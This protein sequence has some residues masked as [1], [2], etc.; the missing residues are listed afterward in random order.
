MTG[1]ERGAARQI[2]HALAGASDATLARVVAMLDGLA[3]RGD[4]DRLLD[5]ARQ[6]LRRLRPP[7]P[8]AFTRLLFLPL[9]GAI[10]PAADWQRGSGQ[11]PRSA[12]G[13]IAAAMRAALGAEA[14]AID[15]ACAGHSFADL[16]TVDRV[17][18][19]LWEIAA[20][21]GAR[22]S[23]PA[24]WEAETGLRPEDFAPLAALAAG[25]WRHAGP[26]W[27]A[28]LAARGGPPDALVREALAGP[29]G[30]NEKIFSTALATLLLR[31][32]RPGS[33]AAVAAGMSPQATP[34]AERVLDLWIESC[35]PEL[36]QD[37]PGNAAE[38]AE[39]FG[40]AIEDL[41]AS[42]M[43]RHPARRRAL[44]AL[45][46]GTDEACRAVFARA[47]EERLLIPVLKADGEDAAA[48][49]ALEAEARLLKRLEVAARRVGSPDVYDRALRRIAETLIGLSA[50]PA[51]PTARLTATDLARIAE[52]LVGP[53]IALAVLRPG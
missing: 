1:T 45:R 13:P 7:R 40:Q 14:E 21:H 24:N 41:E 20:H 46:R 44:H 8:L 22:L 11:V 38:M 32:A 31:A 6:R 52:I 5:A 26:L 48:V 9:D 27:T 28:M 36:P 29:L 3:V 42:P 15:A 2:S 16:P 19:G 43:A 47:V 39:E 35:A 10:L 12:M 17:G 50:A 49:D 4:A 30:A 53:E 18:R 23:R 33:V 37:D 51:G 25:V 34:L